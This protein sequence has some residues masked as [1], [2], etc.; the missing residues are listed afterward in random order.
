MDGPTRRL[1]GEIGPNF[2][3]Q[4]DQILTYLSDFRSFQSRITSRPI[5]HPWL[6]VK[7]VARGGSF[8]Q[9]WSAPNIMRLKRAAIGQHFLEQWA[10]DAEKSTELY[11]LFSSDYPDHNISVNL[12]RSFP[13]FDFVRVAKRHETVAKN[14]LEWSGLSVITFIVAAVSF[15]LKEVPKSVIEGQLGIQKDTFE[16]YVFWIG[17]IS[18]VYFLFLFGS[19]LFATYR[20][21]IEQAYVAQILAYCCLLSESNAEALRAEFATGELAEGE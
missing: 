13:S 21:K 3:Q 14:R 7:V 2:D 19:S 6:M 11:K 18:A 16:Q 17:L 5:M 1:E 4:L 9:L 10:T 15:L 8:R 20:A 12:M